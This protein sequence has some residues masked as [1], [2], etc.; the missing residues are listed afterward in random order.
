MLVINYAALISPDLNDTYWKKF[1]RKRS[2]EDLRKY[3]LHRKVKA[4]SIMLK[5]H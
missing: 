3:N 1:L 4:N 5:C 2:Q